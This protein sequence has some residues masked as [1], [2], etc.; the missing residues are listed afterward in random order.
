MLANNSVV[1]RAWYYT[2]PVMTTATIQPRKWDG[3]P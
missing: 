1:P 3:A 2:I